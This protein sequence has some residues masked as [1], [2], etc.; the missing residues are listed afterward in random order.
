[1][2]TLE[3]N[4]RTF[5]YVTKIGEQELLDEDGNNTGEVKALYSYPQKIRLGLYPATGKVVE[6][7]FGKYLD[8]D[9]VCVSNEILRKN[10]LLFKYRPQYQISTEE[11]LYDLED[12][13]LTWKQLSELLEEQSLNYDYSVVKIL[14]SLN[15][16]QYG[17]KG[18]I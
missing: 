5:L 12:I 11:I 1:M 3:R 16:Y 14:K 8:I 2:R 17:L 10:T 6:R 7:D 15:S 9:M 18:R 13:S 4:K